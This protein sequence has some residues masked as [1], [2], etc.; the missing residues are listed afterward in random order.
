MC[1]LYLSFSGLGGLQGCAGRA[2]HAR[3]RCSV[4]A[5]FMATKVLICDVLHRRAQNVPTRQRQAATFRPSAALSAICQESIFRLRGRVS[6][7]QPRTR[8][9][10]VARRANSAQLGVRSAV[11]AQV[12]VGTEPP[13]IARRHRRARARRKCYSAPSRECCSEELRRDSVGCRRWRH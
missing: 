12:F 10:E 11:S 4:R 13:R 6:S 9:A 7:A 3:Q 8:S 1:R 5:S 2:P